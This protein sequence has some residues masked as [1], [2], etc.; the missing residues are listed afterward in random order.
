VY[1]LHFLKLKGKFM[2]TIFKI[3]TLTTVLTLV[4][5]GSEP[6]VVETEDAATEATAVE[7]TAVEATETSP[8]T[9][10]G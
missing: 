3:A 8:V 1:N 5:C 7:A 4:A 2:N 6:E 10:V 9:T